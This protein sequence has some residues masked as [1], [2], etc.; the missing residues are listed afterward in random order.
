MFK[1]YTVIELRKI[2][3]KKGIKGYSKMKKD[4]LINH[5]FEDKTHITIPTMVEEPSNKSE[6]IIKPKLQKIREQNQLFERIKELQQDMN[7][8]NSTLK[9][10]ETLKK[11]FDLKRVLQYTYDDNYVFSITS[12]NYKKFVSNSKKNKQKILIIY[13][14]DL[15]D[16]LDDLVSRKITG[17]TA[18]LQLYNY[19]KR[20]KQY[21]DI[22]LN[23]IDKNLKI[24]VN[25]IVIND[26]FPGLIK[27]FEV[28]LANKYKKALI[29]KTTEN[30]Y[31][32]RKLDGVRCLAHIDKKN[33]KVTFYSRQ[34]K[35]FK[36]LKNLEKDILINM[37]VFD[38]NYFLDG[39][40]VDIVN[41]KEDFKGI[42]E[43]IRRKNY[44][45]QQPKYYTFDIIKEEDFYN[46]KSDE[47]YSNRMNYLK[48]TLMNG[49][50]HVEILEQVKY[51]EEE[52][53]KLI[54]RSEEEGWEGLMIRRDVGYTSGR[55]N[56]LVK[57]KKM[58][59]DEYTVIDI[60]VGPFRRINPETGLE[61]EIETLSAVIIDYN[62]VKVGS[63]FTINERIKYYQ[64]PEKI[65]GKII[66]VQFFERT[67]ES[68]RFPVFKG[69]HGTKRTT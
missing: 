5:C 27:V 1:K 9:K 11:Y 30:W 40:I 59:D 64:N 58:D 15:F 45:I 61:E 66:T 17:D 14:K 49:F 46:L 35:I 37:Q 50:Q 3:K 25:K 29:D 55:T 2:C 33:N 53:T 20:N 31:I 57:Y 67:A 68:L 28:V 32:S 69:I 13:Y 39:E 10:K 54:S 6:Q 12:K 65:I 63:G 56:D 4:E 18:L 41:D 48:K 22:I 47:I 36:T 52:F 62:N 21:E 43:K 60:E 51:T 26:V 8:S 19:I 44:T 34:G 38:D 16:L 42:M 24:R 7:K 23:I